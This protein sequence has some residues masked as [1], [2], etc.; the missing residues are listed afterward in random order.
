MYQER[1]TLT[2]H[3]E[4][5]IIDITKNLA[6]IIQRS[7]VATGLVHVFVPGSTAA[8]TT[9]EYEDG[10]LSD[11]NRSLRTIAPQDVPYRHDLRWGDG[12]GRSHVNAAILGPSLTIPVS[13]GVLLLGTW[14]QAVLVELDIRPSWERDIII[15]V[16]GT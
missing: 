11:L 9:I 6:E 13:G 14:Q 15:T 3:G 12:N 5:D 16:Q 10:V 4:G 7:N 2:T 1:I 8:I